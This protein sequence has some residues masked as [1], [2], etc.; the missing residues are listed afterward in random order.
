MLD[1]QCRAGDTGVS[2]LIQG[3]TMRHLLA[4]ACLIAL[5]A[6]PAR[7]D[8]G[9]TK[10]QPESLTSCH[11]VYHAMTLL[12]TQGKYDKDAAVNEAAKKRF[13]DADKKATDKARNAYND[14]KDKDKEKAAAT[15]NLNQAARK[16]EES[17]DELSGQRGAPMTR[18]KMEEEIKSCDALL[19]DD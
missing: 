13:A 5:A 15:A 1:A 4:A 11:G 14:G 2:T 16:Y 8:D 6:G 3:T 9:D 7:A 18:A 17:F 12:A 19:K 10:N